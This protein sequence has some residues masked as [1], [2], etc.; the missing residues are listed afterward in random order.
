MDEN[1][2]HDVGMLVT[3]ELLWPGVWH[4]LFW[5]SSI[6][7]VVHLHGAALP[8]AAPQ[9]EV[10]VARDGSLLR[11][12]GAPVEFRELATP[13]TI[14]VAGTP[15]WALR[16]SADQPGVTLWRL[17]GPARFEAG[18]H[19]GAPESRE[20]VLVEQIAAFER[21]RERVVDLVLR[22]TP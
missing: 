2:A 4:Q 11:A 8:G 5:N 15:V 17:A 7:G 3:G 21:D 20:V 18:Q 6:S 19:V 14:T 22:R 10:S 9:E 13:S 1:E 12:S 16:P